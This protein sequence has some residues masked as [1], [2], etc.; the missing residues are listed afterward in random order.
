MLEV[1]SERGVHPPATRELSMAFRFYH[2]F[3][4]R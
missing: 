1:H 3:L 2:L 4:D